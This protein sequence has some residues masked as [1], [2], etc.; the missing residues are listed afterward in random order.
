[1]KHAYLASRMHEPVL[2]E[3]VDN[4]LDHL[5]RAAEY[6][7]QGDGRSLKYSVISLGTSIE[8][9]LKARLFQEHWSL[10][11]ANIDKAN[12]S[13][14]ATGDFK[15]ADFE[16]VVARLKEICS[17]HLTKHAFEDLNTLRQLRNKAI[18][19]TLQISV[20]QMNSLLAK[21]CNFVVEFTK[22]N[23]STRVNW[24]DP[25]MTEVT[26][27]L[28]HFDHFVKERLKHIE[29]QLKHAARL[30][31]C[32]RCWQPAMIL[33]D[34]APRCAFCGYTV[35]AFELASDKSEAGIKNCP[36]CG[37][38]AC[39]LILF[40]NDQAV[41]RCMACG[42]Q[43]EDDVYS[44]CPRCEQLTLENGICDNCWAEIEEED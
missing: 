39:A 11:F 14:L 23:L 26:E 24:N 12:S 25:V 9:L 35:T 3:L 37:E 40:N 13:A 1:M 7:R 34:G 2:T 18:H 29:P 5:L 17:V 31:E 20:E 36:Q 43:E 19:F 21:G 8:I 27:N 28:R 30:L 33:G 15:S 10:I 41:W 42:E 6:A 32:D 4:A 16:T 38:E 44:V 22:T